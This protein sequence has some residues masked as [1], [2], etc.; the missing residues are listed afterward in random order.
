MSAKLQMEREKVDL[1]K[2]KMSLEIADHTIEHD[3]KRADIAV[4]TMPVIQNSQVMDISR[5]TMEHTQG[6]MA[7]MM[8]QLAGMRQEMIGDKV[9]SAEAVRDKSGRMIRVKVK[10]ADGRSHDIETGMM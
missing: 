4:K 3:A 6:A 5:Q 8:D 2:Q 1:E 7:A 10:K 9:V